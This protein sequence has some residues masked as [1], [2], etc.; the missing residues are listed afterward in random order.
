MGSCS[1]STVGVTIPR[2]PENKFCRSLTL[3]V[4]PNSVEILEL[5]TKKYPYKYFGLAFVEIFNYLG[6]VDDRDIKVLVRAE[7][8]NYLKHGKHALRDLRK[9]SFNTYDV[10][11][12]GNVVEGTGRAKIII[13]EKDEV[14]VEEFS[15]KSR[16]NVLHSLDLAT[17]VGWSIGSYDTFSI[18]KTNTEWENLDF[19]HELTSDTD[20]SLTLFR[21][22]KLE[23]KK[24]TIMNCN[25][26]VQG[27]PLNSPEPL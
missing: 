12:T 5:G 19:S 18:Y 21:P 1:G 26:A 9:V 27:M 6:G 2:S 8:T 22:L 24:I 13:R 23:E 15:P 16:F 7:S 4:D 3:Y 14:L 11:E 10:D 25:F 17:P 20:I